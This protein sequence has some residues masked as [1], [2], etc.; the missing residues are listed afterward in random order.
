MQY[1]AYT[2]PYPLSNHADLPDG[3][4]E[5]VSIRLDGGSKYKLLA[6]FLGLR[7]F[8]SERLYSLLDF[9]LARSEEDT[10]VDYLRISPSK[11]ELQ[12]V[13]AH[14]VKAR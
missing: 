9:H 6:Y 1:T 10:E 12:K 11:S 4:Y 2:H 5:V 3:F 13:T 8:L 7:R 14:Q